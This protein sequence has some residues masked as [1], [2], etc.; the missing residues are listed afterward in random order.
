MKLTSTA[1]GHQSMIPALFT[2]D[3][4]NISPNLSWADIPAEA[5]SLA[6]IMDDPDAPMGTW[7]HW[8]IFNIPAT[9]N[10]LKEDFPKEAELQNGI[11]QGFNTAQKTGYTGPCPPD[12]THRYVF[13]LYALDI[14][15]DLGPTISKAELL[16]SMQGHILAETQLIGL[17]KRPGN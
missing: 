13:T 3:G 15:F 8:V 17:Y 1:F 6:L 9:L 14:L 11:R 4:E 2:C 7:V 5:Q 16:A 10:T 12:G